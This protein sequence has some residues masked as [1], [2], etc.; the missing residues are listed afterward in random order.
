MNSFYHFP[1]RGWPA[2]YKTYSRR[3]SLDPSRLSKSKEPRTNLQRVQ[4]GTE[5]TMFVL[6]S[7]QASQTPWLNKLKIII[8]G[9][10][11]T[12]IL[13]SKW[14][15]LSSS[16]FDGYTYSLQCTTWLWPFEFVLMWPMT[17]LKL[18]PFN[19]KYNFA[20]LSIN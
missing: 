20:L 2:V 10:G 3:C 7:L 16:V 13:S 1:C 14:V 8:I 6:E 12:I 4:W 5:E 9:A 18:L 15:S 19:W 11:L 17:I